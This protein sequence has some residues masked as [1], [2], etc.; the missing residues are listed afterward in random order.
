[1]LWTRENVGSE[2]LFEKVLAYEKIGKPPSIGYGWTGFT[3]DWQ[4]IG[5]IDAPADYLGREW[6]GQFADYVVHGG[7]SINGKLWSLPL[8]S[9][10]YGIVSRRDWLVEVGISDPR[11]ITTWDKLLDALDKGATKRK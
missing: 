11:S 6:L 3:A 7:D 9:A 5:I 4:K 2:T 10:V 8:Q 1:M